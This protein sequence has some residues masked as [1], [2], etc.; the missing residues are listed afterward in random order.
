MILWKLPVPCRLLVHDL[1]RVECILQE[2]SCG[3]GTST[4]GVV[5]VVVVNCEDQRGSF[6]LDI[7]LSL[8]CTV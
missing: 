2:G 3:G 5:V 4:V 1:S 7:S 6:L 8:A